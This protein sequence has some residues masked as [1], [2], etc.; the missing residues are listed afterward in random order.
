MWDDTSP[1]WEQESV[2]MIEG[3]P[4]PIVYWPDVYRY[5]KYSQWQGSKSQWTGWR[6]VVSR[7]CQSTPEDFW[8]EF[9]VNGHAMKFTKIVDELRRQCD[10]SNDD[11]VTHAHEEFGDTFNSLFTYCKGDKVYVMRHKSAIA[12]HY[13]QLK[14]HE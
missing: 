12:R 3:C 13:Q 5:G 6:D 2:L 8:K 11:I 10:I 14:K 9:S 4:I 1:Y 7:Y